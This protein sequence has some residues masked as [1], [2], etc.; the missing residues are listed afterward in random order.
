M[1][2]EKPILLEAKPPKKWYDDIEITKKDVFIVI[3]LLL[4]LLIAYFI[5][6]YDSIQYHKMIESCKNVNAGEYIK[7]YLNTSPFNP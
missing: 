3:G 2:E 7:T 5:G 6:H 1:T 4:M